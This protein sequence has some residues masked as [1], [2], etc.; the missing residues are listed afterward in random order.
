[1]MVVVQWSAWSP[2]IKTVRV[3][4]LLKFTVFCVKL[5]VDIRLTEWRID[6]KK[7]DD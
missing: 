6:R 5:L 7:N 1:M 4:I 2:S 3:Q